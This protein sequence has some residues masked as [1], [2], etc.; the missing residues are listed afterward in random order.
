M[1]I[2]E[3]LEA[4]SLFIKDLELSQLRMIP[5]GENP[6]FLLI[7]RKEGLVDW[8]DMAKEDQHQLTDEIDYVCNIIKT[9]INTD[10]LNVASLGNMVPQLHIHII[11][12]FK[13]DRAWPGAIWDTE[14]SKQFSDEIFKE[15]SAYFS[16]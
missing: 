11:A 5:D 16:V 7:P 10:K 15:W 14:S 6:W 8:S 1:Q 3:R 13:G 12:R 4:D 9:N 2:H